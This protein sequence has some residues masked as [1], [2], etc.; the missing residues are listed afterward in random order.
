MEGMKVGV[1]REDAYRAISGPKPVNLLRT[2]YKDGDV[3]LTETF[4]E[5]CDRA[6]YEMLDFHARVYHPDQSAAAA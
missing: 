3:L 4:E 2:V 6:H 1:M 5:V